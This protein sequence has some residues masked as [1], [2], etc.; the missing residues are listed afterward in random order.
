MTYSDDPKI[1]ADVRL[2][3]HV[4]HYA[5]PWWPHAWVLTRAEVVEVVRAE[6]GAEAA[7]SIRITVH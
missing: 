1:A 2:L 3:M 6:H 4:G 7:R 5:H